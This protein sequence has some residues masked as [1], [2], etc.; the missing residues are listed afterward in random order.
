MAISL[1]VEGKKGISANQMKRHIGVTYKTA[2]YVCHRIRQAMQEEKGSVIGGAGTTVEID[3]TF[4]GGRKRR[5]GV[6]AGRDAKTIVIGLA[7]RDGNI[8]MQT[9]ANRKSAA[10]KPVIDAKLSPDVKEVVTDALSTYVYAVPIGKHRP[11]VHKE[12]LKDKDWTQTQTVE[13]AF[14]LFK[15]GIIGN[16]HK[17][18]PQHLD[19]YLGEFCWRYNRRP[20]AKA[21]VRYGDAQPSE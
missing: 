8:H 7:E 19:R 18:G 2:W 15:R 20:S 4:V 1:M 5:T 10:I 21:F 17:L 3:E 11:T 16:Y 14:S 6:K 9:I 12:E 13:N